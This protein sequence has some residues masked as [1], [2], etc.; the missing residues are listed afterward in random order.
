MKRSVPKTRRSLPLSSEG[1]HPPE[2]R[3]GRFRNTLIFSLLGGVLA[4]VV[5]YVGKLGKKK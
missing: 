5:A 3:S 4:T 2:K 1:M